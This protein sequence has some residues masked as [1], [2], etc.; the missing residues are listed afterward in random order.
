MKRRL[1]LSVNIAQEDASSHNA[2]RRLKNPADIIG[3][4]FGK[5]VVEDF[6]GRERYKLRFN[7][8]YRC[9]CDCGKKSRYLRHFLTSGHTTSC[10]CYK[11]LTGS[12][13]HSWRGHGNI[14]G[15]AW[16]SIR[17]A[18]RSRGLI[19]AITIEDAWQ[20]YEHQGRRCALTGWSIILDEPSAD[21]TLRNASLDRID[22]ER[23]YEKDNIQW[24]H[25]DVN[26]MKG[27]FGSLRFIELCCA[28]AAH[29]KET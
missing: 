27:S 7:Y 23:G 8:W 17:H 11:L 19:L 12:K 15:Q 29:Q 26:W 13:H 3:V 6:L 25:K 9:L 1:K 21:K 20:Q 24:V 14:S 10:G 22:N 5:L 18:A 16:A 4:R 2:Y 28:V